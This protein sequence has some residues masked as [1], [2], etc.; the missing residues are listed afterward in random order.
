[1]RGALG[2][3]SVLAGCR[4]YD[5]ALLLRDAGPDRP[6]VDV[7]SDLGQDTPAPDVPADGALDGGDATLDGALDV[8][9][10]A[11]D[12]PDARTDTGA[13]VP[14]DTGRDAG[15]DIPVDAPPSCDTLL[16]QGRVCIEP[17]TG[18]GAPLDDARTAAPRTVA[19][20]GGEVL[21]SDDATGRIMGYTL[22]PSGASAR[23]IAGNGVVSTPVA[24]AV[25]ASPFGAV[26]GIVQVAEGV[27]L[28]ADV[29]A[30]TIYRVEG[31]VLAPMGLG[32]TLTAGPFGMAFDATAS[33]LYFTADNRVWSMPLNPDGRPR[34]A[35]SAAV[36][37][38]CGSACTNR[39]NGDGMPGVDTAVHNPMG[40]A[41]SAEHV[42]FADRDNCRVRRFSRSDPTR[43]VETYM[44]S[45]C[46]AVTDPLN[47]STLFADRTSLRFGAVTG[48][49]VGT[50]GSVY[51][52]D[53]QRCAI[54]GAVPPPATLSR[55]VVGS[56]NGCGQP[57]A[58]M[59]PIGRLGSIAIAGDGLGL[60]FTDVT[61]QRV[62]RVRAERGMTPALDYPFAMGRTPTA[63]EGGRRLRLGRPLA[64]GADPADMTHLLASSEADGR[65]Y[66]FDDTNVESLL[67]E[68][69]AI[70]N[71]AIM[72]RAR[73][74]APTR[75]QGIALAQGRTV[76][77]LPDRGAIADLVD[78]G[79]RRVAG[80]FPLVSAD[81]GLLDAGARDAAFL[82][83]RAPFATAGF[84]FFADEH[85]RVWR[86]GT[87]GSMPGTPS[88]YAG[89]GPDGGAPDGPAGITATTAGIGAVS[90]LVMD[91]VGRLYITDPRRAVVWSVGNEEIPRAR[92]L[93]G[94]LDRRAPQSDTDQ[95]ANTTALGTPQGIAYDGTERLFVA[96]ESAGRIRVLNVRSGRIETLAGRDDPDGRR[97]PT[98][99]FGPARDAVLSRPIALAYRP[100]RLY[101]AEYGSGRVRVVRLPN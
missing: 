13:D 18:H 76:L 60:Y 9:P 94:L 62:G 49:A 86:V 26:T 59:P 4:V 84:T 47:G 23:R 40:L 89:A 65:L 51:A 38:P 42:Y 5:E 92:L 93:A 24:G 70:P 19:T 69:F 73:D 25:L 17:L 79:L 58:S 39:F 15:P 44:G 90:G 48:V 45:L 64:L 87:M 54:F 91:T 28:L 1:M 29:E 12:V 85:G 41:I 20:L 7:P 33:V 78:G 100:G 97:V 2:L 32:R 68:G 8:G 72:D 63:I 36:G 37:L 30:N 66:R 99:D 95:M 75:I 55:V 31:G 98:G 96:D 34:E 52:L 80:E 14:V 46:D 50:D 27:L 10:D 83:P 53:A 74:H 88:I 101:V 22:T 3:L 35:A 56:R 11:P 16:G 71:D 67:G 21:V 6:A 43:V 77:G 82:A 57:G 81:G 61:G